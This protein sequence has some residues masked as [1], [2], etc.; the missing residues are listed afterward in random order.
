M[1]WDSVLR[2]AVVAAD[3]ALATDSTSADAWLAQAQVAR[4]I[5]PTDMDRGNRASR[6]AL[7]LDSTIA[8]V[9]HE[10]AVG[11]ADKGELGAAM[12]SWRR[13]VAVNPSY[14]QGLAFMGLAHYWRRQY[15]S[16]AIWAES[17]ITVDPTFLLGRTTAGQ[18]AIAQGDFARADAAFD[19]AQRIGT[20]VE[21]LEA[22]EFRALTEASA[23]RP[24][25]ARTLLQRTEDSAAAIL[26]PPLHLVVYR[27]YAYVALGDVG[28]AISWLSSYQPRGDLHFQL[29]LRC[30]P[31]FDPIA[32]DRRFQALRVGPTKC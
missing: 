17:T 29:H 8:P 32:K 27:A 9:W 2:L 1:S 24:D 18:V 13:S 26:P 4:A 23:G 19:A 20:G 11:L 12:E 3:A 31:P 16:A 25:A 6:R 7:A 10:L 30:D 14:T 28:R 5:D 21:D 22:L 15:D